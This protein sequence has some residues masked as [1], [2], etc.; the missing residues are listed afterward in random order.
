MLST[1]TGGLSLWTHEGDPVRALV[2]YPREPHR[3]H[4]SHTAS[5]VPGGFFVPS[6]GRG[7][8]LRWGLAF[9][10]LG[11][12]A[13]ASSTGY[14]PRGANGEVLRGESLRPASNSVNTVYPITPSSKNEAG[15]EGADSAGANSV[16]TVYK[17]GASSK[18][19]SGNEGAAKIVH[20]VDDFC[21]SWSHHLA[22]RA[23]LE[24]LII[25]HQSSNKT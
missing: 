25:S 6:A 14:G 19:E 7:L 1:F 13:P 24:T 9:A 15:N 8:P 4:A 5:A 23:G 12:L 10:S 2:S 22:F 16:N 3:F 18:N 21:L 20:T 11:E 17:I